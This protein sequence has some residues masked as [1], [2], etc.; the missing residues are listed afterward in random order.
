M[1]T[2]YSPPV[3]T[4]VALATTTLGANAGS[5]TFSSIPSYRDYILVFECTATTATDLYCNLNGNT[6]D[7]SYSRV[8]ASGNGS[9]TFSGTTNPRSITY[10][11]TPASSLASVHSIQFL[12]GNATDKHKTYLTRSNR[13]GGGVDMIATRFAS[14]SAISSI[15]LV[16][17]SGFF[18]SGST[19]SLFGI[20]S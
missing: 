14:T 9:S 18:E 3:S 17:G 5:V 7:A 6:T 10:F 1:P 8:R 12:D 20:V 4:Y 2:V 11:G 19:F 15:S 16:T 13:A